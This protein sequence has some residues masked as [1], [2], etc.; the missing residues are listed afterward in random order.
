MR[1]WSRPSRHALLA[2]FPWASLGL[3]TL[4]AVTWN[5]FACF[6][7]PVAAVFGAWWCAHLTFSPRRRE[8]RVAS[9]ASPRRAERAAAPKHAPA[10]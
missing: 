4:L 9:S 5:Y 8:R 10:S 2:H 6:G 1:G 3:L 7:L